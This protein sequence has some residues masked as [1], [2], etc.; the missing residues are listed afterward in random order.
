V[1]ERERDAQRLSAASLAAGD[2]VGWFDRLYTAARDGRAIVPW[3]RGRPN[4][5]LVEWAAGMSGAGRTAMV[6]GC[7]PGRDA[8]FVASLG[9]TTT[10]FDVSPTAIELAREQ[11]PGTS[12]RYEVADLLDLP[13]RWRG[14]FDFVLESHNVQA[15]PPSLHAQAS[16]AVASLVAPGGTLLVLAAADDKVAYGPPWPLTRAEVEAFADDA[17]ALE[18]AEA[19]VGPDGI[20]RWRAVFHR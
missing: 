20:A 14:G 10:A 6:V 2:P 15:L 16:A 11:H 19:V 12:V 13:A 5:M 17:L 8:E 9:F 7:G 1:D 3:D 18:S 4:A